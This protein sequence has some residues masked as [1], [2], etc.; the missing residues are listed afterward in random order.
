M[1]IKRNELIKEEYTLVHHKSGLDIYL[2]PKKKHSSAYAVIGTKF[3]SMDNIFMA[4]GDTE[5]TVLPDGV[6]HFL[7]HKL[8]EDESGVDAFEKFAKYGGNANAFTSFSKTVFLFSCT[9]NFKENLTVL[10]ETVMHPHFT[11]EN[12][13]KEIGIISEEIRMYDDNA[14]WQVYFNMLRAMYA[15]HPIRNDIAG[16]KASISKITPELLYKAYSCFYSPSN[17][18]LVVCGDVDIETIHDVEDEAI[19]E[20]KC[21]KVI[22]PPISEPED[23][24]RK[25]ISRSMEVGQPLFS[26]GIKEKPAENG[27]DAMV[28]EAA[29]EIIQQLLFGS[30]SDFYTRCYESGLIGSRFSFDF[31]Y[32]RMF[33][34]VE[35]SGA[36]NDPE[37]LFDEICREITYRK[38]HFFDKS[39]F[40]RIKKAV[41]ADNLFDFES[42]ESIANSFLTYKFE[43][44]DMLDYAII[45][46]EID[47][48]TVKDIFMQCYDVEKAVLS[49]VT[50]KGAEND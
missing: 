35:I 34:F 50:P 6:A 49:T 46:A 37:K 45:L 30:S 29:H 18:A 24:C 39:D 10:L 33:A 26:I 19:P 7:E 31:A 32:S 27:H 17:M 5:Y 47:Y 15:V 2:V 40:E 3:G 22:L 9:E 38:Q 21:Q 13:Q 23:V 41:Y 14:G 28:R 43:G 36:A 20:R 48:D 8:F 1:I 11:K 44:G 42:T 25:R 16:S 4:E 12:V